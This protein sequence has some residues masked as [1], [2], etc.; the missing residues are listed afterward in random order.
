MLFHPVS[1]GD[2]E[3]VREGHQSEVFLSM[4]DEFPPECCFTLVF[5]GRRGNLD[6][7]ASSAEEAQAWIQGMR[8]LI[9]NLQNMDECEKLDQYPFIYIQISSLFGMFS[10]GTVILNEHCSKIR[11]LI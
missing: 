9:E 4:P 11:I 1:V 7:V 5:R 10:K 6:L 2:V 3:A 8:M